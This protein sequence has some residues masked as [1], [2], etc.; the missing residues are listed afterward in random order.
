MDS[1]PYVGCLWVLR[2]SVGYVIRYYIHYTVSAILFTRPSEQP[3]TEGPFPKGAIKQGSA[4][5]D[6]WI[7]GDPG[8]RP[9]PLDYEKL[10]DP[11]GAGYRVGDP[12]WG[13]EGSRVPG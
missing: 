10:R 11:R 6:P 9:D 5:A 12:K 2:A 1:A 4:H 13:S 8:N 7:P 3:S